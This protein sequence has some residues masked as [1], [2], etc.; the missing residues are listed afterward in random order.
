MV[1]YRSDSAYR[2]TSKIENK[3]LDV[4][5]STITNSQEYNLVEK[6]ISSKYHQRPDLMAHDLYGN[7]KLWW[8]FLEFNQDDLEDPI[9]DFVSG[10]T[11]LVPTRFS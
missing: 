3:Y 7:S 10:L 5:E 2:N 11:I 4:Y 6:E 9:L 1:S 8:V